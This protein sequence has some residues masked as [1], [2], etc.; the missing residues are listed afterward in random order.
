MERM[1]LLLDEQLPRKIKRVFPDDYEIS[2]VQSE[3]WSNVQNG[4]LLRLAHSRDFD[5][6]ITADKNMPYQQNEA[7]LLISVVVLSVLRLRIEDLEPLIPTA[8]EKLNSV[9]SPTFIRIT[10]EC[11]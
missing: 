5:A 7:A 11:T 1:K 3:G 2:S 10:S 4:E 8:I 9:D 6:L